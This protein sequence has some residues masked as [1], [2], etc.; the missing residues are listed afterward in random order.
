MVGRRLLVRTVPLSLLLVASLAAPAHAYIDGGS[1]TVLFQAL[2]AGAATAGLSLRLGWRKLTGRGRRSSA[3]GSDHG[4][5][6]SAQ[7][8]EV[9]GDD[10]T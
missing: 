4:G 1:A 5:E 10:R 7:D 2:L 8:A 9:T 3:P 6:L